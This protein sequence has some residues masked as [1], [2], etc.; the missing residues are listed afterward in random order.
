MAALNIGPFSIPLTLTIL[1]P[2]L[3]RILSIPS[4]LGGDV[5]SHFALFMEERTGRV[6]LLEPHEANALDIPS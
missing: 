1:E 5:L 2:I 4:L 3:N 6:L